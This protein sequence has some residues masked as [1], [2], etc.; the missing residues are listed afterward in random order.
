MIQYHSVSLDLPDD[1]LA[2]LGNA[3]DAAG[4]QPSD[5]LHAVLRVILADAP[6]RAG[7]EEEVIRREIH[8]SSDWLELQRR[9]RTRGYVLRRVP[10]GGLAVH[11]VGINGD[12]I[13]G[14]LHGVEARDERS[15]KTI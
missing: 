13:E 8:Q 9:L 1:V 3:A 11:P 14:W 10:D 4:C 5:Y 12:A 7:G 15:A 6:A 2:A